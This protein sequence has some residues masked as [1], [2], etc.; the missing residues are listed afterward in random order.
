MLELNDPIELEA[1]KNEAVA[2]TSTEAIRDVKTFNDDVED[3][4]TSLRDELNSDV[5]DRVTFPPAPPSTKSN[6]APTASALS[7]ARDPVVPIKTYAAPGSASVVV[8]V[9]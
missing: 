2:D 6:P 5:I 1:D 4:M 8:K 3:T 7:F 9:I